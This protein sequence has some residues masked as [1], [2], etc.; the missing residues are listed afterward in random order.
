M[1]REEV[2]HNSIIT[3]NMSMSDC[4]RNSPNI[5]YFLLNLKLK[6]QDRFII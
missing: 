2:K 6:Q 1:T 5:K 3:C 4:Q